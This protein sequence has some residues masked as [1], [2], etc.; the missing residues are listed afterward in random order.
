MFSVSKINNFNNCLNHCILHFVNTLDK[1]F[2]GQSVLIRVYYYR[3]VL[4]CCGAHRVMIDGAISEGVCLPNGGQIGLSIG[5]KHFIRP[6]FINA[7]YVSLFS[8][9]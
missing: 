3:A 7:L 2:F 6:H 1:S 8:F 4:Y 5:G 9:S